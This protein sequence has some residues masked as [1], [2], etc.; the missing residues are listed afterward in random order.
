MN[1]RDLAKNG[2]HG[3][4]KKAGIEERQGDAK[5]PPSTPHLNVGRARIEGDV[6]KCATQH[7]DGGL[8]G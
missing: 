6:K 3:Q 5:A 7:W 4:K 1:I 2:V 8:G